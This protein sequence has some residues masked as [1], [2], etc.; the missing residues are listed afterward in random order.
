MCWIGELLFVD[1]VK[2]ISCDFK[3]QTLLCSNI[4]V[5]LVFT[6]FW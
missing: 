4:A 3:T 6:K 5:H 1:F 2:I